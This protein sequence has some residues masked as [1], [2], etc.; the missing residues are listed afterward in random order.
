[1]KSGTTSKIGIKHGK[2][3]PVGWVDGLSGRAYQAE[4]EEK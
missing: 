4:E 1:M 2:Y 3:E